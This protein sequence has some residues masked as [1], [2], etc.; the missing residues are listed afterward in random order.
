MCN[1]QNQPLTEEETM[2]YKFIEAGKRTT[3]IIKIS[4]IVIIMYCSMIGK[5]VIAVL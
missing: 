2:S 1:H 4:I 5:K 3:P